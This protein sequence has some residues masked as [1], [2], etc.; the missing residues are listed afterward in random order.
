MRASE[1]LGAGELHRT[2]PPVYPCI[3]LILRYVVGKTYLF[4]AVRALQYVIFF[5]SIIYFS[6][7]ARA[8]IPSL[9]GAFWTSAAYALLPS[10]ASFNN[11]ILTES[12]CVSFVI[13]FIWTL[14]QALHEKKY[15]GSALKSGLWLFLMIFLRP[16]MMCLIPVYLIFWVYVAIR[17]RNSARGVMTAALGLVLCVA[18][19]SVY[20]HQIYSVYGQRTMSTAS[21]TNN[22]YTLRE[23]DLIGPE[24]TDNPAYKQFLDSMRGKSPRYQGKQHVNFGEQ[25]YIRDTINVSYNER[26]AAV[27]RAMAGNR[28]IL[29]AR[30]A[31]RNLTYLSCHP[32]LPDMNVFPFLYQ[33]ELFPVT[34]SCYLLFMVIALILL[35]WRIRKF[36]PWILFLT[37]AAITGAATIGAMDEWTRLFLPGLPPALLLFSFLFLPAFQRRRVE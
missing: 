33:S 9:K 16:V 36:E 10:F 30:I 8:V 17:V 13:F 4:A 27:E 29:Y 5:I 28:S 19:I 18:A 11:C 15:V 6:K 24:H 20:K 12:L 31:K 3:L 26:E 21:V 32:L 2:R 22:Y 23:L 1:L 7:I 34:L 35:V 25:F 14:V 37:S